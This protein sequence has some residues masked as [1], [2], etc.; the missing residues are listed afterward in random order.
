M[1]KKIQIIIGLIIG[2]GL[3]YL[4]FRG[5]DWN[6]VLESIKGISIG[7]MLLAQVPFLLSIIFRIKRWGY[8]VRAAKP[9]SF[10]HMY[11]ATQI[12]FLANF[13]LPAR[14]GEPIRAMVLSRL[15][16]IPFAKCFAMVALDRVADVLGLAAVILVAVLSFSSDE[17][18]KIADDV[19]NMSIPAFTPSSLRTYAF[20]VA[21]FITSFII[22]LAILYVRQ[23][24]ILKISDKCLGTFSK[25]LA[26]TANNAIRHFADGLHVFRSPSDMMKAVTYSMFVWLCFILVYYCI[27]EAF[28]INS[29]WYT[30]FVMTAMIAVFISAPGAPGMIG[31]YHIPIVICLAMLS[32]LSGSQA[33]AVAIV[34]HL[35]NLVWFAT[36][37]AICLVQENMGLF[38]LNSESSHAEEEQSILDDMEELAEG[39]NEED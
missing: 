36:T 7:W 24:I 4:V 1:R 30:P 17:P 34:M 25:K 39:V 23:D 21:G 18:V 14:A 26:Q 13:T 3:M 6:E 12:G 29:P 16:K 15:A 11:S 35:L 22:A 2:I 8:I 10:R 33:K 19:F 32:D 28:H 31:Q 38:E 9:V 37:G 5:T 20:G 27:S